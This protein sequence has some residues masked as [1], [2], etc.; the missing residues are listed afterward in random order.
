M[1]FCAFSKEIWFKRKS[2]AFEPQP[3]INKLLKKNIQEN[4]LDNVKIINDGWVQKTKHLNWMTLIIR[5]LEILV[6]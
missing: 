1:F 4:N 3:F 6:E 2:Y 5:L